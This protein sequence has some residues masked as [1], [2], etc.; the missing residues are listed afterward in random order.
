V[1]DGREEL[2]VGFGVSADGGL[3][4]KGDEEM[5]AICADLRLYMHRI[6]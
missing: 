3:V 4:G 2:A 6:G 1:V 5:E